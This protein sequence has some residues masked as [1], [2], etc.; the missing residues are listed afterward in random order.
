VADSRA[1]GEAPPISVEHNRS[2]GDLLVA[3]APMSWS[4]RLTGGSH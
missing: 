4:D 2:A 1:A 3:V